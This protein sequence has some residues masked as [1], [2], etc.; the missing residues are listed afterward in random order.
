[1]KKILFSFSLLLFGLMINGCV[2]NSTVTQNQQT[3]IQ[4]TTV[5][6]PISPTIV[7]APPLAMGDYDQLQTVQGTTLSLQEK[8]NGFVFPQYNN[9]IV[10][11][12]IFG[13]DCPYC[14]EEMPIINNIKRKYAGNLQLIGIQAQEPMSKETASYLIQKFEMNYPI[15]DKDEGRGLLRFIQNTYGWTGILPYTLIIKNGVTEYSFSGAVSH[16]ELDEAI[17]SLI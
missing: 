9:K 17:K 16:Q 4:R 15:I 7:T 8:S 14:F 10:L 12:Q 2:K 1:M 6:T 11:L 13:Q 5:P 3:T